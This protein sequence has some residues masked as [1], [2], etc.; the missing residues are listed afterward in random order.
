MTLVPP[1]VTGADWYSNLSHVPF[2][3]Y[4]SVGS[5]QFS[6]LSSDIP[7]LEFHSFDGS[8]PKIWIKRCENYFDVY[9]VP[10]DH[11]VKLATMNFSGPAA[12][13][14]QPIEMDVRKCDWKALC[15]AVTS[16]FERD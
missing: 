12:F 9:D 15:Q 11:W 5:I 8:N 6:K 4:D 16:R 1:P 10:F 14:M 7:Q 2:R 13:W 3:G